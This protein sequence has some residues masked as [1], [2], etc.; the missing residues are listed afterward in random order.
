MLSMVSWIIIWTEYT[1]SPTFFPFTCPLSQFARYRDS[2]RGR[3][4]EASYMGK[5][6]D[7]PSR[8][9]LLTVC[10]KVTVKCFALCTIE[11]GVACSSH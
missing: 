10:R 9:G 3:C 4:L 5:Q 6:D 11:K 7:I 8:T 1:C 2:W